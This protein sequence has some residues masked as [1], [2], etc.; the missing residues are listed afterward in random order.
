MRLYI[1][2]FFI[3]FTTSS[4]KGSNL[5]PESETKSYLLP[6]DN[7]YK[8]SIETIFSKATSDLTFDTINSL[9]FKIMNNSG[10]LYI[11]VAKHPAVPGFVFKFFKYG[12]FDEIDWR[13]WIKRIQGAKLIQKGID[14]FGYQNIFMVPKKWLYKTYATQVIDGKQ[15]PAYI[16]IAEDMALEKSSKN[17][18]LWYHRPKEQVLIALH[19]M[20]KTYGLRDS[21]HIE[22]IPYSKNGK[23]AFVDTE[24]FYTW[25]V[26]YRPLLQFLSA[27]N[28]KI[29]KDLVKKG[30][31]K[32]YPSQ[33]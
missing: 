22:N 31:D 12:Q 14:Q 16:L 20:L 32:M 21:S 27:K 5:D 13:Y 3:L 24:S 26:Y 25:P 7:H 17:Q 11:F 8:N 10:G 2:F 18:E 30:G 33:T 19:K 28:R 23:I 15:Y 1:L 4:L 6:P 29:W 9:G